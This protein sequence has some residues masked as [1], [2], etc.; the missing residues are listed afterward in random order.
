MKFLQC[1]FSFRIFGS[2]PRWAAWWLSA[3][4]ELVTLEESFVIN[5][6]SY[7]KVRIIFIFPISPTIL[8]EPE[9]YSCNYYT[10]CLLLRV[11]MATGSQRFGVHV[12][13]V[14]DEVLYCILKDSAVGLLYCKRLKAEIGHTRMYLEDSSSLLNFI[15]PLFSHFT[16]RELSTSLPWE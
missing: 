15:F 13:P 11:V 9:G 6:E 10:A 14:H 8:Q 4:E 16:C 12:L 7:L 2:G 3:T 5:S 1:P